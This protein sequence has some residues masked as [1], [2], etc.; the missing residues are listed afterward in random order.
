MINQQTFKTEQAKI[1]L[2]A[3]PIGNLKDFT[4]RSA[5]ILKSVDL[6]FCE[7][8][9]TSK[10]LLEKYDIKTSTQSL[11]KFN[12]TERWKMMV[13]LIE[14]NKTMAIISDAGVP[15]IS[16]P[17]AKIIN[18]VRQ[19][20]PQVVISAIGVGPAYLHA[21]IVS[22][23]LV[24]HHYFYGFLKNRQ[25][26]GKK[27]ELNQLLN[28]NVFAQSSFILYESV[29][30]IKKTI[31]VLKEILPSTQQILV[32]RELTKINEQILIGSIQEI[33]VFLESE[34]F[35]E[36]GEFVIVIDQQ[37]KTQSQSL[38]TE[39]LIKAVEQSLNQGLKLKQAAQLVALNHG[40]SVNEVY[41]IYVKNRKKS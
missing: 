15:V 3:T 25:P 38:T 36:K 16:D 9:R 8:T 6:I 23:F 32:A 5:E 31:A 13:N 27:Q 18:L 30:R 29:H 19:N 14:A 12:E 37:I 20:Y 39:E 41:Q 22:G 17:G 28:Q 33:N 11:H 24:D 7:D 1:Y 4:F 26:I 35:V 2:V 34:E 40:L 21:L 10:V